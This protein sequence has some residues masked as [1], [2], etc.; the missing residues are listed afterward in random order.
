[1]VYVPSTGSTRV[2]NQHDTPHEL[3]MAR[4]VPS[5]LRTLTSAHDEL[6]NVPAE[7]EKYTR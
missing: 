5:G 7:K 6:P 4:V 2:S 3:S 1:M